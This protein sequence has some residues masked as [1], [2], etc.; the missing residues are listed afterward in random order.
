MKILLHTC[1]SNCTIHPYA[2]LQKSG[3]RVTGYWYNPNIHPAAEYSHRL[4]SMRR[5]QDLWKADVIYNDH[6][7]LV[8]FVRAVAGRENDRCRTCYLMRLEETARV[9]AREKFDAFSTSLLISPYQNQGLIAET[10]R[11]LA[12]RFNVEFYFQDFRDG[13]RQALQEAR[14]S[15]FYLQKHCGCIYS[16]QDAF[17]KRKGRK[18]PEAP[19]P[20]E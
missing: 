20:G 13:F 15:G 3:H 11:L 4:E 14:E 17:M 18:A 12:A 2:V 5:F 7:G 19:R 10:G 1:C 16:E 8:E 6:Y 9:A